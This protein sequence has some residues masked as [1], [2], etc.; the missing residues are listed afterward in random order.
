MT[1]VTIG[2]SVTS[3]GNSAF[4]GCG[5][6]T[7]VTIPNSVTTIGESAFYGCGNLTTVTIG[8]SV[9]TI[10]ESAFAGDSRLV[11]VYIS[12]AT[13]V[14]L[15]SLIP[16]PGPYS[17]TSSTAPGT[18]ISAPQFYQAPHSINFILPPP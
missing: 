12:N 16:N 4:S 8:N 17:W 18:T 11:T 1:T 13:A 2:N 5:N 14:L 6:L 7:S 15:G 3:I 9:T 10:G